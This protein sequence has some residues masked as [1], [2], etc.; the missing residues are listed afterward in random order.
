MV[1][2]YLFCSTSCDVA[3]GLL[4][5]HS[6]PP[7]TA[8]L[9]CWA[10]IFYI[11]V[12]VQ[13]NLTHE[14]GL[15]F[16]MTTNNQQIDLPTIPSLPPIEIPEASSFLQPS[17]F[18]A[19]A[20]QHTSPSLSTSARPSPDSFMTANSSIYPTM[21]ST[22]ARVHGQ[23][24][25]SSDSLPPPNAPRQSISADSLVNSK[26]SS[27]SVLYTR[28]GNAAPSAPKDAAESP[29]N[30][31]AHKHLSTTSS[32]W[33]GGDQAGPSRSRGASVSTTAGDD[34]YEPPLNDESDME[35]TEDLM[36]A[37]RKGKSALR[38][39]LPPGE[40]SLPSRLQTVNSSPTMGKPPPPIVP[41]RNSSLTHKLTKQRSLM[42]VNTHLPSVSFP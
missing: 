5:F 37:A 18:M 2:V 34:K 7:S 10:A 33:R 19:D 27:D 40:L 23:S 14:C 39:M 32:A 22:S 6:T 4:H 16:S 28:N 41:E 11:V 17:G 31:A 12:S 24:S 9:A 25:P 42:S 30:D 35:L 8:S 36:S 26:H 29:L 3:A 20:G 21:V 13:F 1:A 15:Q 38:R